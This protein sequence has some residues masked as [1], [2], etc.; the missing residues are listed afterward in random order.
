MNKIYTKEFLP[1]GILLVFTI[2]SSIYILL[3]NYIFGLQQCIGLSMLLISTILYLTK[4]N[5]Y[6]Y[7][8]GITLILGLFNLITF[9]VVNFTIKILFIPIQII[10]LLAL[11]VYTKI[12]RTKISNLFFKRREI[13]KLE[14][15]AYYQKKTSFFKEKFSNLN[16]QEKEQKLNQDLVPEAKKAL[17]EIK[18]KRI[19]L[20]N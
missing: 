4:P 14:E 2:G 3:N 9:P 8:F 11:L 5:I 20:N 19:D 7:F 17:N 1:I 16:D 18:A 6:R 10:P 12:Y 15:E 13:D